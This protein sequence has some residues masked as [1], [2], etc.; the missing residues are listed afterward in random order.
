MSCWANLSSVPSVWL[1][2][3]LSPALDTELPQTLDGAV[4][5]SLLGSTKASSPENL[6]KTGK[7]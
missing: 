7:V 6:Y 2:Q 4:V 1:Q 3:P 5:L